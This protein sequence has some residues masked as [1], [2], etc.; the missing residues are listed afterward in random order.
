[1]NLNGY[2]FSFYRRRKLVTLKDV[3][4]EEIRNFK[5]KYLMHHLK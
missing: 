3:E 1:V 5:K 2:F 4:K